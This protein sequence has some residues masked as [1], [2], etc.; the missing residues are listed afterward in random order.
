MNSS[1]Q[2]DAAIIIQ[3]FNKASN[4]FEEFLTDSENKRLLEIQAKLNKDYKYV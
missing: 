2:F 4:K 1:Q 3:K